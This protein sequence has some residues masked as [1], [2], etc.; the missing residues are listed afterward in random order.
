ML[1]GYILFRDTI[2][3][4]KK[5]TSPYKSRISVVSRNGTNDV[6]S[7][8]NRRCEEQE[9]TVFR[10]KKID[11]IYEQRQKYITVQYLTIF[12]T[13]FNNKVSIDEIVNK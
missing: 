5:R 13:N 6:V 10:G 2:E 4:Q 12:T 3:G 1:R 7:W 9:N 11:A 8:F